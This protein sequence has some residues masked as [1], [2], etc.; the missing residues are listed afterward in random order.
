[1]EGPRADLGTGELSILGKPLMC[2]KGHD[3]KK[4]GR[5]QWDVRLS[6]EKVD[7]IGGQWAASEGYGAE[8]SLRQNRTFGKLICRRT[9]DGGQEAQR[10]V[11]RR[12]CPSSQGSED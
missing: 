9:G 2:V 11:R 6:A 12:P 7:I 5:E 8:K 10:L 4:A 1:M 3:G